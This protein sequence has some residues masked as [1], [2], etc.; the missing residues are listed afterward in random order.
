ML[1]LLLGGGPP[2]CSPAT[3]STRGPRSERRLANIQLRRHE[4]VVLKFAAAKHVVS[5]F[6]V[7]Q[8]DALI[9]FTEG[10]VLVHGNVLRDPVR[11]LDCQ[12]SSVHGGDLAH[13]NFLPRFS[14]KL[15]P[16]GPPIPVS[17]PAFGTFGYNFRLPN[18]IFLF[19]ANEDLSPTFKSESFGFFAA[20]T[21]S[22]LISHVH[23]RSLTV[24]SF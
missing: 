13:D 19:A 4:D 3:L 20:F 6:E 16:P 7:G 22:C 23:L 11:T 5:H 10:S 1:L 15:L 2:C 18:A 12:L 14:R 24:T 8:R 21:V 17:H 9:I